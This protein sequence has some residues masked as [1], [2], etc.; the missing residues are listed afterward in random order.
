MYSE[1]VLCSCLRRSRGIRDADLDRALADFWALKNRLSSRET[2][3][4]V[5]RGAEYLSAISAMARLV[6]ALA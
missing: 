6:K 1:T 3:E 4:G 5:V 2:C